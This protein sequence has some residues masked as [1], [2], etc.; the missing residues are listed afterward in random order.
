VKSR[1][2]WN[3]W[4]FSRLEHNSTSSS[5]K[6]LQISVVVAR[7]AVRSMCTHAFEEQS[8]LDFCK[9]EIEGPVSFSDPETIS[10]CLYAAR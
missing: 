3:A 2:I 7:S 1:G 10:R 6:V 8:S 9:I 5:T 4:S